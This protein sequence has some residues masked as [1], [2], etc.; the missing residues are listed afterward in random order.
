MTGINN[1]HNGAE[2]GYSIVG[3][4]AGLGGA[5]YVSSGTNFVQ[6][7]PR[8]GTYLTASSN[9]AGLASY[10]GAGTST[11]SYTGQLSVQMMRFNAGAATDLFTGAGWY[12]SVGKSWVPLAVACVLCYTA[13]TYR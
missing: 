9:G 1:R 8:I 2:T 13:F 3:F 4:F 6:A 12:V 10:I 11:N 7:I 5:N